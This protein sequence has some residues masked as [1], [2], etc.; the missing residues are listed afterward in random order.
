MTRD[1]AIRMLKNHIY[2]HPYQEWAKSNNE[3][4]DMAIEALSEP[5]LPETLKYLIKPKDYEVVV[6][7]KDCRYRKKVGTSYY[8]ELDEYN[9]KDADFCSWAERREP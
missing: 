4:I 5:S 1:E 7:C 3:A 2:P 9:V 6:R 8:C